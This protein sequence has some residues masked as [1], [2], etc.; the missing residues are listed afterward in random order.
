MYGIR[1]EF[2]G[3]PNRRRDA[4]PASFEEHQ[5]TGQVM[6]VWK[7]DVT[8]DQDGLDG[9]LGGLLGIEIQVFQVVAVYKDFCSCQVA[10][11]TIQPFPRIVGWESVQ[12]AS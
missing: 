5:Q 6:N 3:V 12:A 11:G 8:P 1:S 10:S 2:C 7:V 9:F 4:F